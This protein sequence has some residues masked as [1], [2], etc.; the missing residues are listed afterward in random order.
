MRK[1][2]YVG[3][4]GKDRKVGI[5]TQGVTLVHHPDFPNGIRRC[6]RWRLWYEMTLK[7]KRVA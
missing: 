7:R 5:N 6:P 1:I 4:S 3:S 2:V